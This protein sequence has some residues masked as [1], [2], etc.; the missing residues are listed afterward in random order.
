MW[1]M[2]SAATPQDGIDVIRS[3]K[4]GVQKPPA[5]ITTL[6]LDRGWEW[7]ESF[8]DGRAVAHWEVDPAY[9]DLE[10][11][12]IAG[13]VACLAEQVMFYATNTLIKADEVTR[14]VDLRLS[15]IE[16][17]RAG[18]IRF[19]ANVEKYEDRTMWVEARFFL[20]NGA[21]AVK[22]AAIVEVH[23]VQV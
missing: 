17:L 20:P 22:A 12:A 14:T 15:Y 6:R 8:G 5:G 11:A 16:R 21:L 7:I 19:E 4:E 18:R 9:F 23:D 1:N 3:I 2:T 13:W 10:D